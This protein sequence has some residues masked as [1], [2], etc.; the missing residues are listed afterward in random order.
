MR[1]GNGNVSLHMHTYRIVP[2]PGVW[3]LFGLGHH[4]AVFVR[5]RADKDVFLCYFWGERRGLV[6]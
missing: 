2:F 4:S 1:R 6:D 5:C 3:I